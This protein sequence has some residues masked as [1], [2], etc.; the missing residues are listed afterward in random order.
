MSASAATTRE[1]TPTGAFAALA[2]KVFARYLTVLTMS[3]AGNWIRVTAMGYLVYDLTGDPFKLG[4]ISFAQSAP[5]LLL[6]PVA[7]A[8]VDRVNRRTVLTLVQVA[9]ISMMTLLTYLVFTE[10]V[11]YEWLLGIAMVVGCATTF[12]WPARLSIV[13]ALVSRKEL[14]SAVALNAAA[15][16]GARVVGP[17]IAGFLIA[18]LGM[19]A[20]FGITTMSALPF[21]IVLF[22]IAAFRPNAAGAVAKPKEPPVR[23]LIDGYRYIWRHEELRAMLSVD[24]VPIILGMSYA[25]MAPAIAAD[26]LGLGSQGF[27]VMLTIGGVGSLTGTLAVAHLSR[28]SGRGKMVLVAVSVFA[29]GLIAYGLSSSVWLTF[30]LMALLGLSYA[31]SSTMNDTLIQL[32]ADDAY[33]GRVMAV[34]STFWGLS[35]AGGLLAGFLA[36]HIGVQWAVA[37]NGMLV[38]AYIPWLL[39][40]TPMRHI[41]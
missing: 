12:D 25:A 22:T 4:L 13:P 11:T 14:P 30:P 5:Q 29:V 38:L 6:S 10:R 7:G 20:A 8:V 39:F 18:W 27:G 2:N 21:L 40:H 9:L 16:N 3:L 34:Y 24:V 15:F 26:V 37:I 31:I 28:R 35:P 36:N 23:A 32:H 17:S 33:R 19:A 1:S 41:D